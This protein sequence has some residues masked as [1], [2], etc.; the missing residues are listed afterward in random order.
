LDVERALEAI[1]QGESIY[2]SSRKFKVPDT[3]LRRRIVKNQD[4]AIGRKPLLNLETEGLLAS[5]IVECAEKGDPRTK[6]EVVVAASEICNL[7][8]IQIPREILSPGWLVGFMR[9]HKNISFRT[10]QSCT[11]ASAN[12]S[13]DDIRNFFN[14]IYSW[15]ERNNLLH[16]LEDARRWLNSDETGFN[17]NPHVGK[18]IT[19]DAIKNGFKATGIFPLN[20]ENVKYDRCLGATQNLDSSIQEIQQRIEQQPFENLNASNLVP[21]SIETSGEEKSILECINRFQTDLTSLIIPDIKINHANLVLTAQ[22]VEQQLSILRMAYDKQQ[23][24]ITSS[25]PEPKSPITEVLV[26]PKPF[27]R[28]SY[29]RSYKT[30]NFGVMTCNEMIEAF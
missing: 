12:V 26:P 14:N 18:F 23:S 19:S 6:E 28:A 20:F 2:S 25:T 29:R 30:K 7:K 5:W 22:N 27:A 4:S 13:E 1:S 10:P 17:L 16:N 9:R 3:T 11:R 8:N 24:T 15:M 21:A